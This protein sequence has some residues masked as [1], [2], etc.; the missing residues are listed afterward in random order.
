MFKRVFCCLLILFCLSGQALAYKIGQKVKNPEGFS[1]DITEDPNNYKL[2]NSRGKEFYTQKQYMK[3]LDDFK[4]CIQINPKFAEAYFNAAMVYVYLK[5]YDLALEYFTKAIDNDPKQFNFYKN[6]A[7][8]YKIKS[9]PVQAC[10]DVTQA[11]KL[12]DCSE[13]KTEL[14]LNC[15]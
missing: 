5:R 1:A 7:L 2:Y 3:A 9:Q 12:G 14:D 13:L 4:Q 15:K 11:C 8:L 6:R 10:Q